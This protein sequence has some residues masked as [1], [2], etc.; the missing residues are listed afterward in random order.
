MSEQEM[1]ELI[2]THCHLDLEDFDP[3]REEVIARAREAGVVQM[4]TI[5]IDPQTSTRAVDLATRYDFIYAAV[6]HHP[7]DAETLD[8][9]GM[10]RLRELAGHPKVRAFGEIGL[11]F[12]RNISPQ[13]V[14]EERFEDL[15]RLGM[16]L[17]LPL[18]IHDRD[19]HEDVYRR[20]KEAGASE[21]G[22][23]IHCFSGDWELARRFL[24]LGF[25]IS[26]PG[27]IT[28]PKSEAL[29]EVV[30]QVPLDSLLIETDAP[31]LAPVPRRGRR[32]EPALVKHTALEAARL[33]EITIEELAAATTANARRI[34][35]ME[36]QA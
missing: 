20:L 33:R 3:D 26:V 24:D 32:N 2:D 12:F 34:F 6:G 30:R 18:V 13:K 35:K 4:V 7:H 19:A 11:D 16:E 17:K 15:I 9:A 14:Q 1:I 29:R 21:Y 5:G 36:M 8:Q 25:L 28:F 22:G 23:I 31:F 10:D 27:T